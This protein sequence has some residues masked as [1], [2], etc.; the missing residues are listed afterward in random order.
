MKNI[1]LLLFSFFCT[2]A[3]GQ[4]FQPVDTAYS[5]GGDSVFY[6]AKVFRDLQGKGALMIQ[7]QST[8]STLLD[9]ALY[10]GMFWAKFMDGTLFLLIRKKTVGPIQSLAGELRYAR[11]YTFPIGQLEQKKFREI[12]LKYFF[13]RYIEDG[14]VVSDTIHARDPWTL[15]TPTVKGQQYWSP[16]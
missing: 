8:D 4:G 5:D 11:T 9:S 13:L 10:E 6:L 3:F 12:P 15:I 14:N 16:R 1:F 2:N 7:L